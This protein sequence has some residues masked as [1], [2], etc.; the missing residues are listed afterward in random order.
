MPAS[1]EEKSVWV[2]LFGTIIGMG[3]YFVIAGKLLASGVKEM[4]AYAALFIVATVFMVILL[5]A[6][7]IIAAISGRCE[8]RDERDRLIAWRAEH[9]SSWVLATGVFAAIVAMTLSMHIVWVAH[10]LVLSLVLSEVLGYTL[11]IMYYRRGV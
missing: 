4:P 2:Q 9:N 8:R 11:R 3:G 10:T 6:G 1:F 5:I 7:H